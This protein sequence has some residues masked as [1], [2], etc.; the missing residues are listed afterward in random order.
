MPHLLNHFSVQSA[1]WNGQLFLAVL[2]I[3]TGVLACVISSILGQPFDRRQRVF[4]IAIVVLV[5]LVG[6]LSYLPFATSKK[7]LPH[8]FQRKK[9]R[10]GAEKEEPR[11]S[12]TEPQAPP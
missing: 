9:K 4:W 1:K 11:D 6:L 2:V 7:D 12:G 10:I 5:P 8:I 3:W